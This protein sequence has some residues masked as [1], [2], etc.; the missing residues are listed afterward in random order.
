MVQHQVEMLRIYSGIFLG[1]APFK[2]WPYIHCDTAKAL[3]LCSCHRA[4]FAVIQ[5]KTLFQGDSSDQGL[6]KLVQIKRKA[7]YK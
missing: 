5:A 1:F 6:H 7:G 2:V 3:T 4:S